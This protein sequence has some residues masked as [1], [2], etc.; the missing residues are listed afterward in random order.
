[1]L[2]P[3]LDPE[4]WLAWHGVIENGCAMPACEG[5]LW[6]AHLIPRGTIHRAGG[7]IDDPRS[8]VKACGGITGLSGHH[9]MLDKSRRLRIP[10]AALP[11]GLLELAAE[12]DLVW[13]LDREYPPL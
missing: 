1:M 6:R 3:P 12:L 11:P 8:W 9:G 7:D 10:R 4:C 2:R 5:R 13:W